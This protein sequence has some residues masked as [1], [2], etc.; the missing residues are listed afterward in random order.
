MFSMPPFASDLE[1]SDQDFLD[2]VHLMSFRFRFVSSQL[3]RSQP[4]LCIAKQAQE[5][6][7]IDYELRRRRGLIARCY[8]VIQKR[9]NDGY[10]VA[11]STVTAI[12]SR[13]TAAAAVMI[14][15]PIALHSL[16]DVRFGAFLLLFGVVNWMTLGNFGVQSALGR[17]I[18]SRELTSDETPRMVGSALAFAAFTTGVTAVLVNIG[19]VFWVQTVGPRIHIPQHE[20]LVAGEIMI[21]LF[22][23]QVTIQAFEGVLIGGLKIYIT[24][25]TRMIGSAF[26]F[27]CLLIMPRYWSSISVFVIATGGGL[28]FGTGLSAVIVLKSAGISFAHLRENVSKLRRLAA[29]GFPFMLIGITFLFQ[30][31]IPVLILAS[32]RGVEA[33][34]DF[35]LFIRLIIVMVSGFFMVTAPLWPAIMSARSTGNWKWIIR[36]SRIAGVLVCGLGL[37]AC[38]VVGFFGNKLLFIWTK[39]VMVESTLFQV[40]FGLYFL[41]I[42]W[43]HFWGILAIGLGQER[44]VS[45][46]LIAESALITGL[47]SALTVEMGPTGMILG[48]VSALVLI[49]NWMLPVIAYRALRLQ[50]NAL[51]TTSPMRENEEIVAISKFSQICDGELSQEV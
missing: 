46:V 6:T 8:S 2:S 36:S 5:L 17:M 35:G 47:G 30:T 43:S 32:M 16:G 31:H 38:L 9:F 48:A 29:S 24:N 39:R 33:S 28:L 18:A 51:P 40:L 42:A 12:L 25:A 20:L 4:S 49:S 34:I 14:A 1:R 13:L 7:I 21:A 26:T 37:F 11:L 10:G 23:C 45:Y 22:Y 3:Q 50:R 27:A 44:H 19:L 41:Q 15:M